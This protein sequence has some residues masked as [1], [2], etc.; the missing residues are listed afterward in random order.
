MTFNVN[1]TPYVHG[2]YPN[3][4]RQGETIK[5][6]GYFNINDIEDLET[7]KFGD[8]YLCDFTDY[9][10]SLSTNNYFSVIECKMGEAL[11]VG[12]FD[13]E[14]ITTRFGYGYSHNMLSAKQIDIETGSSYA[15]RRLPE[16]SSINVNQIFITGGEIVI[17][18]NGF[19]TDKK[20]VEIQL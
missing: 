20:A 14:L 12:T 1:R 2:I 17:S 4:I 3:N 7:V 6:I 8:G 10:G 18:G 19:G 5:I 15:L 13:L 11:P 9:A 16:I